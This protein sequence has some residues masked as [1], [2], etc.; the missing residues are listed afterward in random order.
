M[1][2]ND[3]TLAYCYC[4][5]AEVEK[6]FNGTHSVSVYSVQASIPM[7]P[8]AIWNSEFVQAEELFRE[9]SAADN[10]LRD[11]RF[12]PFCYFT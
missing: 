1:I 8:A 9:P 3:L 11:N 12:T 7:E 4:F 2:F 6:E 5:C 10:C